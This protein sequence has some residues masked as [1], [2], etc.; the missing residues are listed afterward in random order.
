LIQTIVMIVLSMAAVGFSTGTGK[1][2]CHWQPLGGSS[3][4]FLDLSEKYVSSLVA[5]VNTVASLPG[6]SQ[7]IGH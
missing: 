6:F 5:Y 7:Q 3:V 2:T 1:S 4:N